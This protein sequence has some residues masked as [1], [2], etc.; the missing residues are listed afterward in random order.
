MITKLFKL[1]LILLFSLSLH[2][3]Y[4]KGIT[5][6]TLKHISPLPIKQKVTVIKKLIQ[7]LNDSIFIKEKEDIAH[8]VKGNIKKSLDVQ[9]QLELYNLLLFI[10]TD[11]RQFNIDSATHFYTLSINESIKDKKYWQYEYESKNILLKSAFFEK[12]SNNSIDLIKLNSE[13]LKIAEK[14]KDSNRLIEQYILYSKLIAYIFDTIKTQKNP[15]IEKGLSLTNAMGLYEKNVE[16]KLNH[17]FSLVN[18]FIFLYD[19]DFINKNLIKK[20]S[21]ASKI[22]QQEIISIKNYCYAHKIPLKNGFYICCIKYGATIK[23]IEMIKTSANNIIIEDEKIDD[24]NN[25]LII[26]YKI[27]GWYESEE[28]QKIVQLNKKTNILHRKKIHLETRKMLYL[29]I[30]GAYAKI[31]DSSTAFNLLWE[32]SLS[33]DTTNTLLLLANL[34]TANNRYNVALKQIEVNNLVKQRNKF[35][36]IALSALLL[37]SLVF[38]IVYT[39][40]RIKKEVLKNQ[41]SSLNTLF[42]TQIKILDEHNKNIEALERKKLAEDLHNDLAALLA[43]SIHYTE[44][45]SL[46]SSEEK[47]KIALEKLANKLENAYDKTRN[48]SHE[49][50]HNFGFNENDFS[51][52]IKALIAETLSMPQYSTDIVIDEG[53]FDNTSINIK[54]ALLNI[55]QESITNIIKYA[56]AKTIEFLFCEEKGK[57][58]VRIKDDGVGFDKKKI[59]D[60]PGLGIKTILNKIQSLKASIDFITEPESGV[61]IR[62]YFPI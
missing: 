25:N 20:P 33:S 35:I 49:L 55:L 51:I 34:Q 47:T 62:M 54:I 12:V 31:G 40:Q 4:A 1:L 28:Y 3:C 48:K 15:I 57:L 13:C 42:Q 19:K 61:E 56:N 27:A 7:Q 32:R 37:L 41:I 22:I 45:I 2:Y 50:Y 17:L 38:F 58:F 46:S 60:K 11:E 29:Y 5:D 6:S 44:T 10:Y 16:I 14:N 18:S 23:D 30:S 8:F 59:L 21:E 24:Y 39:R 26:D 43:H 53:A 36:I 9:S 52:K